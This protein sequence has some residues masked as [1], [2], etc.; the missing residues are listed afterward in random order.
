MGYNG[1]SGRTLDA[2]NRERCFQLVMK[3]EW[4][5]SGYEPGAREEMLC[6]LVPPILLLGR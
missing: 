5:Q 4:L 2:S 3:L 1:V 6:L